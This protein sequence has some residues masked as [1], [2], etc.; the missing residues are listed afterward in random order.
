MKLLVLDRKAFERILGF[1]KDL[2][3]EDYK[4]AVSC[5]G[6]NKSAE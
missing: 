3:M 1:I 4:N 2:L 6:S 5:D